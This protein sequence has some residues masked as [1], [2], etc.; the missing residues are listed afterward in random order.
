MPKSSKQKRRKAKVIAQPVRPKKDKKVFQFE[1]LPNEIICLVFSYLKLVDLLRCGQVSKRFRSY[2]QYLWPKK[3]NLCYKNVPVVFLQR[4]LDSGCKYLSL[5]EA[6][7]KGTLNL[8]KVSSLKY[9]NLDAI[10]CDTE[11][12]EKLL[13]YCY[14]LEKLSLSE[15]YLSSK[16]IN[17][18]SLQNGKTLR[19]LDLSYCT[20]YREY[21]SGAGGFSIRGGKNFQY[22]D[23]SEREFGCIR[24]IVKNCTELRELSL[25][26]TMLCKRSIDFLASNLTSNI[27]KLDLYSQNLLRDR[28]VEKLVTRC[29]K[30]SEL[31]LGGRTLITKKSLNSIAEH[32]QE[33]LV[34]L[35]LEGTDASFDCAI[36][37]FKLR[38]M[39]KLRF[40]SIDQRT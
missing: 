37:L 17:F 19:V 40:L 18:T 34:Q 12:S 31:N 4:L 11:N 22:E 35:N 32:L 29:N 23:T 26:R 9:L 36:E 2:D 25:H 8:Q 5:C 1:E 20:F 15:S 14:S 21:T 10:K 27:E 28:H 3:I 33:T 7:L 6:F 30:I 24:L 13:E 38:S 39:K 16:L